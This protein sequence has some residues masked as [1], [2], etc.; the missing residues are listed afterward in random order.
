MSDQMQSQNARDVID[1]AKGSPEP[2]FVTEPLEPDKTLGELFSS[3]TAD[4]SD[5]MHSEVELAK[6]EIKEEVREVG[7][8][9]G[10]LG[11]GAF[12]GY[13]GVLL[14]SFALVALLDLVMPT[15]LAFFIVGALY[16]TAALVLGL[17]GR[18]EI[19]N[20]DPV[21]HQTVETIQEDVR[22]AKQQ[23]S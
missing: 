19:G 18:N 23:L 4:L 16:A 15:A 21:P 20:V 22:W 17:K 1:L 3:L 12:C 10:L 11:A 14:L 5:L 13:L 7:K 8:G 6:V 2:V 9:A